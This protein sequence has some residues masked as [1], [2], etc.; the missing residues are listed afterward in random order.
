MIILIKEREFF[1]RQ[2]NLTKKQ[3]KSLGVSQND[4]RLWVIAPIYSSSKFFDQDNLLQNWINTFVESSHYRLGISYGH[5]VMVIISSKG[6][7]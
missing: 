5:G 7:N 2:S 4:I 6:E 1:L 3:R